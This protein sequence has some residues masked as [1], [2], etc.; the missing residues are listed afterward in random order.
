MRRLLLGRTILAAIGVAVWAFGYRTDDPNVRMAGI[1]ILAAA[2]LLRFLPKR[3][4]E[5]DEERARREAVERDERT[6][7]QP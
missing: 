4:F 1:G 5:T 7:A 2:L 3:W 6:S